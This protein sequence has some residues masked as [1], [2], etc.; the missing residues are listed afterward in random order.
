MEPSTENPIPDPKQLFSESRQMLK[1]IVTRIKKEPFTLFNLKSLFD[2]ETT[3]G[4]ITFGDNFNFIQLGLLGAI[5]ALG[6]TLRT[7]AP[8]NLEVPESNPNE[9]V[10]IHDAYWG[11]G[12]VTRTHNLASPVPQ[13]RAKASLEILKD[14]E[15]NKL[16]LFTLIPNGG[17]PYASDLVKNYW[18]AVRDIVK[19]RLLH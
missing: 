8:I 13:E 2:R 15:A 16:E 3:A 10:V 19:E 18:K 17:N 6:E 9:E 5:T 14:I 11:D 1:Q 7:N 4:N 12:A